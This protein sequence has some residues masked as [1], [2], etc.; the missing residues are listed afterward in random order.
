MGGCSSRQS[1]GPPHHCCRLHFIVCD[2]PLII[3]TP[4]IAK[5]VIYIDLAK[6]YVFHVADSAEEAKIS[7]QLIDKYN[8]EF[9]FKVD[10]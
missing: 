9:W 3:I 2:S 1:R 7:L 5:V 8:P 4:P 10:E 6:T